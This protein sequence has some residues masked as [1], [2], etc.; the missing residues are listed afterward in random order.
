MTREIAIFDLDSALLS[1][2][3]LPVFAD[4]AAVSG[5][6]L[7]AFGA[8]Y[9]LLDVAGGPWL[10][11]AALRAGA[12]IASGRDRGELVDLGKRAAD[13]LE[14]MVAPFAQVELDEHRASGRRL[15]ITTVLPFDLAEAACGRLGID[16]VIGT[17]LASSDGTYDGRVEGPVVWGR[18]KLEA[19][20]QW[21]NAHGASLKRS[22]AY[23]GGIHDAALLAQVGHPTVVDPDP[24]LAALAWLRG[25]PT[26]SFQVPPGVLTLAGREIQELLRPLSRPGLVPNASFEFIDLEHIPA[27]GPAIVCGNHRSY[28]DA[29]ALT[30]AIARRGRNARFLGKK[31]VF[32]APVVGQVGRW[33]GGI[34]V[35]RGSGSDQPLRAAARALRAGE[36]ICIMPQGTIPRG[37]AFFEPELRGRWGAAQ[38]AAMTAAPVI[39]LGLWGTEKVWPR[40]SRL[41]RFDLVHRPKVTVR[42]GP[43]VELF[44]RDPDEDTKRIMSAIVDLLPPEARERRQ[45]SSEELALTYPPGY[46]GDPAGEQGR[47]PGVD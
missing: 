25:W 10:A 1:R 29:N 33:V 45:P 34:R 8:L 19:V 17:R 16:N 27:S 32:D 9:Q 46:R 21:A 6:A 2:S 4:A 14:A 18:G 31:E 5:P 39:P 41:P 20:R 26:R 35:E 24:Q 37:P 11:G 42:A 30:L 44:Y 23:A 22:Y 38:L 3:P 13:G 36:L 12:R 28:F 15:V 40:S 7:G 47:R 43:P